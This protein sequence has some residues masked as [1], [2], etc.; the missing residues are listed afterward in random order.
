[1]T[2]FFLK[3]ITFINLHATSHNCK[4]GLLL[5]T[6]VLYPNNKHFF[7]FIFENFS[8]ELSLAHGRVL[9]GFDIV[10]LFG[11]GQQVLRLHHLKM[12]DYLLLRTIEK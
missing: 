8:D 10:R 2:G 4:Q 9:G 12:Q 6:E 1:M 11:R 5:L 3:K 7:Y